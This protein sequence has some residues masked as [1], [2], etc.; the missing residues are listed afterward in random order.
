MDNKTSY[1]RGHSTQKFQ[2]KTFFSQ[3]HFLD[4]FYAKF[5]VDFDYDSHKVPNPMLIEIL[6]IFHTAL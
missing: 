6:I 5:P 4:Y 2:I 3:K 1:L